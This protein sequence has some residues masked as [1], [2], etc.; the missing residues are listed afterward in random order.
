MKKTNNRMRLSGAWTT[1]GVF[2]VLCEETRKDW[3]KSILPA[4]AQCKHCLGTQLEPIPFCEF[5]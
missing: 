1:L 3:S 4:Y 5:D 2:C